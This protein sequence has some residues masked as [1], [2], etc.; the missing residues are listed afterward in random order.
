[1]LRCLGSPPARRGA[2]VPLSGQFKT[3]AEIPW[4]LSRLQPFAPWRQRTSRHGVFCNLRRKRRLIQAVQKCVRHF[5]NVMTTDEYVSATNLA[6]TLN[7]AESAGG[8]LILI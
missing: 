7:L 2:G 6:C 4:C 8:I 1:M 5:H 3:M